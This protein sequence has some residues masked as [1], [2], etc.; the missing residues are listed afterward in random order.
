M[1][2]WDAVSYT[3][4]V[5]HCLRRVDGNRMYPRDLVG[6]VHADGRIWSR[7]LWEIRKALGN[8]V[9]DTV[10]LEGQ[11]DFPGTTMPDLARSTVAAAQRIYGTATANAVRA[12]FQSRGIL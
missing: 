12:A 3:V 4:A 1:A 10:I 11:F 8:V 2:D 9:A 6:Q 7:A 5:P